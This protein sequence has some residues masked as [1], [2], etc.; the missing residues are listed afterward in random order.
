[1]SNGEGDFSVPTPYQIALLLV[2]LSGAMSIIAGIFLLGGAVLATILSFGLWGATLGS[3]PDG[4][5]T[6]GAFYLLTGIGE[7]VFCKRIANFAAKILDN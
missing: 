4:L 5:L 3:L 2:R 6:Y 1:M 7:I